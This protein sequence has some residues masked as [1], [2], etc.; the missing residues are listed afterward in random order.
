MIFIVLGSLREQFNV[1]IYKEA[2]KLRGN[3]SM[4]INPIPNFSDKHLFGIFLIFG[5]FHCIRVYFPF[6]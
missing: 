3:L 1:S 2:G 4:T 6:I 5:F